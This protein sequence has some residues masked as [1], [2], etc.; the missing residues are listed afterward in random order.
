MFT[1]PVGAKSRF[2]RQ[3][4]GGDLSARIMADLSAFGLARQNDGGLV[5][6]NCGGGYRYR[7]PI[8][9]GGGTGVIWCNPI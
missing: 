5:R 6:R 8:A 7:G 3:K 4:Y 2:I 9:P 1:A